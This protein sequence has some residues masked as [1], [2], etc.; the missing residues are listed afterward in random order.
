MMLLRNFDFATKYFDYESKA[1]VNETSSPKIKGWYKFING[2]LTALFVM[3]NNLYFLYGKDKFLITDSHK[4][5]IK[6]YDKFEHEFTLI[7][8]DDVLVRFPYSLP[9]SKSNIS[10]FE[11]IDEEDFKWGEFMAKIINDT[12]GKRN[13]VLNLM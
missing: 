3:G 10:P 6:E 1:E 13:F 12:E 9:E 5:L 7:N 11:Y 8:V 2:T 4:V